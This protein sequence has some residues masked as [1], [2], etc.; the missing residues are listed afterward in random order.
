VLY[1]FDFATNTFSY[2]YQS[3]LKEKDSIG[4]IPF[5]FYRTVDQII[6]S[7]YEDTKTKHFRAEDEN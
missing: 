5:L 4:K 6:G 3:V 2:E 7:F 1:H